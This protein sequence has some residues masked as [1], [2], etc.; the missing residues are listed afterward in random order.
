M[1][2]L[3]S[4]LRS[5]VPL[6]FFTGAAF[7]GGALYGART[8]E[9]TSH[10]QNPY[11]VVGQFGRV[12][13][14]IENNYVDP[15]D[16]G[17]IAEGAIR[18]MVEG[19]DPH[20]SYMSAEEFSLFASETEGQFGGVGIEVES[21]GD[22]L[23][24]IAPIEGSPAESAGIK[25]GDR[26]I[27][28]DGED[29]SRTTLDKL[30]HK[31]R[32]APKSHVK[33][34]VRRQ[35]DRDLLTF[36][37]VREIVHVP[38]VSSR[39]LDGDIAYIRLKQFQEHTH[40]ELL[41][42]AAKLRTETQDNLRGIVLD[43]RSNPGGLVDESAEIADEFLD[44]GTIYTARHRGQI[45]DEVSAKSGGSFVH[46]P[47]VVLVNEYSASAAELLAGAL[48]DQK[49][50]TIV[51]ANTFGKGSVQTILDL[52]GGAGM[53]LTTARYYTPSGHSVQADGIH[54]DVLVELNRDPAFAGLPTL[55]ERDLEGHLT[56]ESHAEAGTSTR[57]VFKE[58]PSPP[59]AG[60]AAE[61][62]EPGSDGSIARNVPKDPMTG[63]DFALRIAYQTLLGTVT[64]K[65]R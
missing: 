14:Q 46:V 28:I 30:V 35:P 21:R 12:L 64:R 17:K 51:G 18:G 24:V 36:D 47:M 45:V 2:L 40:D 38:S 3:R 48:Q 52:P 8:A 41:R 55:H 1:A 39:T 62:P 43:L 42:A 65:A 29:V 22:Q 15:V 6:G 16:R 32:G 5:L 58:P 50:A 4:R 49:R 37:L 57:P 11:A 10:D 13:V 34:S 31:M 25:S 26:I 9:A 53:R 19:L 7:L 44:Q 60:A 33:L 61:P 23:V 20:S 54:P 63:K 59:D 27:A 56:P